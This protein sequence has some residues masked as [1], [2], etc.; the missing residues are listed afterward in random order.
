MHILLSAAYVHVML[1]DGRLTN[2]ILM[3]VFKNELA[4]CQ[5]LLDGLE[6]PQGQ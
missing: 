4:A 1:V 5:G 2:Q 6:I 3:Q